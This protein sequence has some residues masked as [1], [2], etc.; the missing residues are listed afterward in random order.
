MW[1]W[2]Q[3]AMNVFF[4]TICYLWCH[5]HGWVN[6]DCWFRRY[7]NLF[8]DK[9]KMISIPVVVKV[10]EDAL[11]LSHKLWQNRYYT[12]KLYDFLAFLPFLAL[13]VDFSTWPRS[14]PHT[15]GIFNGF[16]YMCDWSS[17]V[18]GIVGLLLPAIAEQ[19]LTNYA[20]NIGWAATLLQKRIKDASCVWTGTKILCQNGC[21][22]LKTLKVTML[23]NTKIILLIGVITVS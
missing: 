2:L 15:A 12:D 21:P 3:K 20:K 17:N 6:N 13:G 9:L 4:L 14:C 10:F 11:V 1:R 18:L 5:C 16:L 22:S 23:K 7:W 8:C 19:Q